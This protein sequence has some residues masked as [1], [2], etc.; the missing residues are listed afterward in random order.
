MNL[1]ERIPVNVLTGF[2]GSGK[3]TLLKHWLQSPELANTAVIINELG[4]VGLDHLLVDNAQESLFLLENGCLCCAVREDLVTS[5]QELHAKRESGEL[6]AFDR[7]VIETTGLADPLP[8]LQTLMMADGVAQHFK[9]DA[10]ITCVDGVNGLNT[11]D[12][13][14]EAVKQVQVADLLLITK[15]DVPQAQD[16]AI[17]QPL[18]EKLQSLNPNAKQTGVSGGQLN[19]SVLLESR[20]VMSQGNEMPANAIDSTEQASS[21]HSGKVNSLVLLTD[22]EVCEFELQH[23]LDVAC[24]VYGPQLLRVKG[25]VKIRNNPQ[26]PVLL[27]AVQQLVSPMERLPAWPSK[28]QRSRIVLIGEDLQESD[29]RRVFEGFTGAKLIDT[30]A[31][32]LAG[33]GF[34]S[35]KPL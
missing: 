18:L 4:S 15:Q 35:I 1:S 27:H 11:L 10:V 7:V 19:A 30:K 31:N 13:H 33:L 9:T 20:V 24:T 12:N 16:E 8:V 28:D 21:H 32:P 29:I 17:K 34:G 23:W 5:L 26:K 14:P 2:L 6:P 3:T 22:D 25:L